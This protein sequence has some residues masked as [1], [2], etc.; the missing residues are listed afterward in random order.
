MLYTLYIH[1][2][3]ESNLHCLLTG[4]F[5]KVISGIFFFL[6][7]RDLSVIF[8]NIKIIVF[9]I[10]HFNIMYY[11]FPVNIFVDR[12]RIPVQ[13]ILQTLRVCTTEISF[14]FG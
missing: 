8:Y 12:Y 6:Q 7:Q 13:L 5:Q 11:C 2:L 3:Y 4:N 14:Y 10:L 9:E 1:V